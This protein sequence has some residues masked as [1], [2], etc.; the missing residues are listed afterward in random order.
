MVAEELYSLIW[1]TTAL[2]GPQKAILTVALLRSDHVGEMRASTRD[3]MRDAGIGYILA[4]RTVSELEE[5]GLLIPL[6]KPGHGKK[7]T[8]RINLVLL[9]ERCAEESSGESSR[10]NPGRHDRHR[11]QLNRDE[12]LATLRASR[13]RLTDVERMLED[14]SLERWDNERWRALV[15]ERDTLAE[16]VIPRLTAFASLYDRRTGA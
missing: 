4:L 2:N 7:P 8:Y 10:V 15:H 12:A 6:S 16:D 11:M 5:S 13:D 3:W 9:H 1:T 14:D